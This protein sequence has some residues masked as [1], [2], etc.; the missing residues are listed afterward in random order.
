M[1]HILDFFWCA[2]QFNQSPGVIAGF[3]SN[4]HHHYKRLLEQSRQQFL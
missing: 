3:F 1:R 4:Y 2:N